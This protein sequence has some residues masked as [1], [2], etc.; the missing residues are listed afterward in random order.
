MRLTLSYPMIVNAAFASILTIACMDPGHS[1]QP[2]QPNP[3]GTTDPAKTTPVGSLEVTVTTSGSDLDQN[4]YVILGT[5]RS[6]SEV[7]SLYGT[8]P[9]NGSATFFVPEDTYRIRLAEVAPNCDLVTSAP[10]QFIVAKTT[11][12]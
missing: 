1:T 10:Q 9:V 11:K 3:A 12:L 8:L 4:G 2:V 7:F 6:D 5:R